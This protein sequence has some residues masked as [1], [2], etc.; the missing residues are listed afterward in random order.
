M[1]RLLAPHRIAS[2]VVLAGLALG[3]GASPAFAHAALESTDPAAGAI[4]PRS[5]AAI[6][7]RF[8]EAVSVGL[9]GVR[10][11]A[12]DGGTVRTAKPGI[13]PGRPEVVR[14]PLPRLAKGTYVVTWRVVSDDSHPVRGAFTFSVQEVTEGGGGARITRQFLAGGTTDRT[15][16][17]SYAIVRFVVFTAMALLLGA[18]IAVGWVWRHAAAVPRVRRTVWIAWGVLLVATA[19]AFCF[20]GAYAGGLGLAGA[21]RPSVWGDL[22]GTRLGLVLLAR[23]ALVVAL[24]PVVANAARDPRPRWWTPF[25]ALVALGI[26]ATPALGGHASVGTLNAVAVA[27]DALHVLAMSTWV[28][29]LV[30]LILLLTA[31]AEDEGIEGLPT[32]SRVAT[33]AVL[34]VVFTG[35][36]R[37]LRELGGLSGIFD[38]AYGV[39]LAAKV[40]LVLVT[41]LVATVA[42]DAVH[43]RW[44]LDPEEV[45]AADRERA[46]LLAAGQEL[47]KR[48]G[49]SLVPDDDGID[50]LRYV[51]PE[52]TARSRLLRSV[53]VEVTLLIAVLGVTAVLVNTA[54]A[55]TT[56]N[57]PYAATLEVGKLLADVSVS[58]ARVGPNEVHLTVLDPS[59]GPAQILNVTVEFSLPS[60]G[61]A[62]ID[63]PMRNAGP[64]HYISAGFTPPVPGDWQM[65]LKVLVD[66]VTEVST[67]ATVPIR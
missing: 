34:V 37:G 66:P 24:L 3:L 20:Q 49:H 6:E 39:L 2:F 1:R 55:G 58:P 65:T 52:R 63:V 31:H 44:A 56:R 9:G 62:P 46:E 27:V 50:T 16:D 60:E 36:V 14:Q 33:L 32:W 21:F 41:L 18:L 67:A 64:A 30:V 57:G 15:V 19:L 40:G 23:L 4:V 25:T 7:L 47:P 48:R 53:A 35:V 42:R 13:A 29:G 22:V 43:R 59:G 5:P 54:P 12:A 26:A 38:T 45:E 8:S 17:V 28:G 51:L 61:I 10:V 11:I